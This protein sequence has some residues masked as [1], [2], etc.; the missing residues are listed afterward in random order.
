M[1]KN[2]ASNAVSPVIAAVILVAVSLTVAVAIS[3]WMGGITTQYTKFEK[4]EIKSAVC[5]YDSY[6]NWVI[7]IS[8]KNTGTATS[9]LNSLYV[10]DNPA[11]LDSTAPTAAVDTITTDLNVTTTTTKIESGVE[12]VI[13]VWIGANHATLSSGTT[14][15]VKIHSAGGMDY[16]KLIE[17]V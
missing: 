10:N 15:N 2:A 1:K 4:V 9:T 6:D 12:D 13:T 8:L 17:L 11:T 7:T 14:V 3:F 16:I 5:S